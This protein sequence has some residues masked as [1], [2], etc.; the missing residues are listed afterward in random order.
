MDISGTLAPNSDRLNFDDASHHDITATIVN[1]REG[2][3]DKPLWIDLAEYPDRPWKP[4]K[5]MRRVLA[6]AY[7]DE[8]D[9]WIGRRVV[10]YGDPEVTWGG[11]KVGGLRIRALSH[12]NGP[13]RTKITVAHRKRES[14]VVQPLDGPTVYDVNRCDSLE[15][16]RGMWDEADATTQR[17]ITARAEQIKAGE[18]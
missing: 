2:N 8:S 11:Q 6:A 5:G 12:L 7:G 10:L 16:L 3:D 1:V 13:L 4:P 9:R 15:A 17:A 14:I 18:Q